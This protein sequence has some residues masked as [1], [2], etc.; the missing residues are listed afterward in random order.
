MT[1]KLPAHYVHVGHVVQHVF[2]EDSTHISTTAII[3]LDSSK[4]E[5][6][7][8]AEWL[9]LSITPKSATNILLVRAL[10][11]MSRPAHDAYS[12]IL[13]MFRDSDQF[14]KSTAR[15]WGRWGQNTAMPVAI[16]L[17]EVAGSIAETTYKIRL[18]GGPATAVTNINGD[19]GDTERMGGTFRSYMEIWEVAA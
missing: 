16:T 9:T 7:E 13:A 3:P 15:K 6:T 10:A 5:N 8:G 17:N 19:G 2:I 1:T 11:H 12:G 4:P 18:G 14:A